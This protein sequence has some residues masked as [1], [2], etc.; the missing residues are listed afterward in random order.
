MRKDDYMKGLIKLE[1][2]RYEIEEQ[3]NTIQEK[4]KT[5][6]EKAK[7]YPK[8]SVDRMY[9]MDQANKLINDV[10]LKHLKDKLKLI[11]YCINTCFY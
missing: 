2:K 3:I 9:W 1:Q 5:T 7:S 11:N 10:E 6:K 8:G 4:I